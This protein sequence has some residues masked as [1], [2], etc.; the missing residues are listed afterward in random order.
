M[1]KKSHNIHLRIE[2]SWDTFSISIFTK[3][4]IAEAIIYHIQGTRR[5][6]FM[7][8]IETGITSSAN[9]AF[10]TYYVGTWVVFST[11]YT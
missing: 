6:L 10:G 1:K 11:D 4:G 5:W 3:T 8:L 7:A 2:L 9:F